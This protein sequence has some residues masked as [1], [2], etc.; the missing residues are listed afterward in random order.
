MNMKYLICVF[1]LLAAP[2]SADDATE[3]LMTA[4][5]QMDNL[6]AEFKQTLLDED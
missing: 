4:L 1:L 2:A 6:T 5:K 3:R